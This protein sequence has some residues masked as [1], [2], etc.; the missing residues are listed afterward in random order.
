MKNK[1]G[2]ISAFLIVLAYFLM[3]I[4]TIQ[5]DSFTYNIIN[6]IGGVGLAYR[7]WLDRNYS[8]FILEIIFV[9]IAIINLIK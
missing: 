1:T 2:W 6:F 8:N 9:L 7:V 5:S 4:N 3:T